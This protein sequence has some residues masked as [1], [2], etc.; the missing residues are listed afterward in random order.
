MNQRAHVVFT[1]TVQ[2]IGFRYTV[3][4]IAE[5]LSVVGWVKN[6]RSGDVE[7]VAEASR[8]DLERFIE[9]IRQHF[10]AYIRHADIDWEPASGEFTE[11]SIAF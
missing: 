1:G 10:D 5:N 9:D 6:L 2:G 8:Q 4:S 3:R 11:F 7:V